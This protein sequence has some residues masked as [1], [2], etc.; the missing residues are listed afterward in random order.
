MQSLADRIFA[1]MRATDRAWTASELGRVYLK[2]SGGAR[3]EPL[4]RILLRT[5]LRFDEPEP[6]VWEARAHV[7]APLDARTFLLAWVETEGRGADLRFRVHRAEWHEG[8]TRPLEPVLTHDDPAPWNEALRT[9]SECRWIAWQAPL[10]SRVF[11]WCDRRWALGELE[12]PLDLANWVRARLVA[13]GVPVAETAAASRLP[14]L[15]A[16]WGFVDVSSDGGQPALKTLA[17]VFEQLLEQDGEGT[18]EELEAR[19]D[20]TLGSRPVDLT[21]FAFGPELLRTAPRSPGIYRFFDRDGRLL[22]V[23]KARLL[24]RRV[25]SYFRPLPPERGR[26]E[27]LLAELSHLEWEVLPSEIEAL[28]REAEEIRQR[29]PKWNVQIDVHAPELFPPDWFWPLI[30]VPEGEDP[31]RVSALVLDGPDRGYL[32]HL[33]RS[34]EPEVLQ[35]LSR[36]LEFRAEETDPLRCGEGDLSVRTLEAP[37]VW[38]ALRYYLRRRDELP[39]LDCLHLP[40]PNLMAEALL[41]DAAG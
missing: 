8:Q 13:E 27:E 38:L 36:W 32:L 24:D 14:A 30:Y 19:I 4:I 29:S 2:L 12:P 1:D 9:S 21:R 34:P 35:T 3:P 28:L 31:L 20:R 41:A 17:R 7:A 23:G 26:R 10:L 33:P 39:R 37:E 15:A 40:T 5:D 11:Q 22:Y 16:R 18:D 25:N 6:G